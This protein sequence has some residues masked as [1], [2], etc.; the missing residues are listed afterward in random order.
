VQGVPVMSSRV[1]QL[2]PTRCFLARCA[3][4][5]SASEIQ[6]RERPLRAYLT[7]E[8]LEITPM[9]GRPTSSTL[10]PADPLF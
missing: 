1:A 2:I 10:A 5:R 6:F 7:W 8:R 9:W 4:I 3:L